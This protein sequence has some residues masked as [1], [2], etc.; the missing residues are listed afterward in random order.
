[1]TRKP[2]ELRVRWSNRERALVYYGERPDGGWLSHV[3]EGVNLPHDGRTLVQEL[4][5]RGFDLTTLRF[6]IRRKAKP[7]LSG[8]HP[9][10][11]PVVPG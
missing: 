11:P 10:R 3:L 9:S 4:Q 7:C 6:Q 8:Y 5:S 2:A 1:M